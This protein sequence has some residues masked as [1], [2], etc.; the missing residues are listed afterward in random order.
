VDLEALSLDVLLP[1]VIMN[2]DVVKNGIYKNTNVRILIRKKFEN[3]RD[4]LSLVEDDVSGWSK[5][6]EL[7]ESVQNL[8][9]HLVVFLL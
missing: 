2:L 6:E 8:L 5:E 3:D 4:H 9:D 1:I 7:E